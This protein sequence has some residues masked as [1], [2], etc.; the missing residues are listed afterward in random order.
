MKKTLLT[1]AVVALLGSSTF[2][3]EE[4]DGGMKFADGDKN[5]E[6]N[7]APLGGSPLG[8]NGIKLRMFSSDAAIRLGI[9][10][11]GSTETTL[12]QEA[13]AEDT[14]AGTPEML[15]LKDKESTFM[16]NIRPGYEMHMEGT[17]RLSPYMGAEIDFA[18]MSSKSVDQEEADN[19]ADGEM[20]VV[21]TTTTNPSM[22]FGINLLAGADW[23]F[24]KKVYLG[25][26]LGFGFAINSPGKTKTT[27]DNKADGYKD[28]DPSKAGSTSTLNWGPNVNSS[29]RIGFLF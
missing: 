6:F 7:F 1:A 27:S 10:L 29:L 21:T 3:Q 16:L 14:D 25:A 22:R 24:S 2:A 9:N 13:K 15:E 4:G 28:P 23:Y 18:M 17:D 8:M 12:Q 20:E 11:G 26:E 5:F 19:D